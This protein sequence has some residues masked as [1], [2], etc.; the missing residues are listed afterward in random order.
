MDT[1]KDKKENRSKKGEKINIYLTHVY[2]LLWSVESL[3]RMHKN[4]K[5]SA[6]TVAFIISVKNQKLSA[7]TVAFIISCRSLAA[8]CWRESVT[9]WSFLPFL[10]YFCLFVIIDWYLNN[11]QTNFWFYTFHWI[12]LKSQYQYTVTCWTEEYPHK[13]FMKRCLML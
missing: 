3:E 12:L 2:R 6:N 11:F 13:W 4:Q 9:C 7:N 8:V 10:T 1:S 5:L